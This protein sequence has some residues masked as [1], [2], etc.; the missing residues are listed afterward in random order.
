MKQNK[1]HFGTLVLATYCYC[2]DNTQNNTF[3]QN[4]GFKESNKMAVKTISE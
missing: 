4:T 1:L 3:L 2:G